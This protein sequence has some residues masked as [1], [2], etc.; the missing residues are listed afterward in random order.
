MGYPTRAK[1]ILYGPDEM[2]TTC[3]GLEIR[4]P[5][6]ELELELVDFNVD[7]RMPHVNVS[8]LGDPNL[9]IFSSGYPEIT[10]R[11]VGYPKSP[12]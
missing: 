5:G 11:G 12:R 2:N 10:I 7:Y 3:L 9:A 8:H 1:V 6:E 4:I